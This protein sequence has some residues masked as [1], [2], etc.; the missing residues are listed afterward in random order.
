MMTKTIGN[1]HY[2][3]ALVVLASLLTL[4]VARP[5]HASTTFTVNDS[6]DLSDTNQLD[7]ACDVFS[8]ADG[9]QC[10]LRAAIEQANATPGADTIDFNVF[11]GEVFTLQPTSQLPEIRDDVTINGFSQPGAVENTLSRGTNAKLMVQLDGS[12][13]AGVDSTGLRISAPNSVVRG[14]VINRFNAG[15]SISGEGVTLQQNFIGTDP[16]GTQDLGNGLGV[17]DQGIGGV[18]GGGAAKDAN[19]ISG[20]DRTGITLATPASAVQVSHNL[21]GTDKSGTRRLGNTSE[22]VEILG[23]SNNFLSDNTIAFN[24]SDGVRIE[25]G[26]A[27][28]SAVHTNTISS[29][30]IFSNGG[31]G[32]NLI[33]VGAIVVEGETEGPTP[34]DPGDT[35]RGP[36]NLQ[37]KPVLTSAKNVSGKT[38]IRG[39][40]NSHPGES[41]TIQLFSNPKGTDEGK[42]LVAQ[43]NITTD[44]SGN[45]SFTF[46]AS[47]VA[48]GQ[49]MTAT[50]SSTFT[51]DTSEFSAPIAVKDA[52]HP[53]VKS[54][55]PT[56]NATG[57]SPTANVTA[58]FSEAMKASTVNATTVTLKKAGTTKKVAATVTYDAAKKKTT[59]NPRSGLIRGA[60]YVATVNTG[61]K[62][63]AGN[64]LDQNPSLA[65]SQAKTW[66]F[67][68]RN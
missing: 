47:N 10:T 36:N 48:V 44:G 3:V 51:F 59:L 45:R 58:V 54:V 5:A 55:S 33:D 37:N 50:A 7:G 68:V 46:T 67:K 12:R 21:V 30:S 9:D 62:D 42:K 29:N 22:G 11:G 49:N 34:N 14:L 2:L 64:A 19:L 1:N 25:L 6:R 39:T 41:Y 32:I 63:L 13:I 23:S 15:V 38:T 18:I 53:T 31:L 28:S 56:Q 60:T 52:T 8:A 43:K 26:N 61:A 40:L 57:V 65:G 17:F 20:N 27:L 24:G 16:S 66:K 35:D 4:M